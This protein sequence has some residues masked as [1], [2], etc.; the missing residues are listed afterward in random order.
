MFEDRLTDLSEAAVRSRWDLLPPLGKAIVKHPIIGSGFGTTVTYKS[1]DPRAVQLSPDGQFTTYAFE[2]GYLDILLKIGLAGLVVYLLLIVKIWRSGW[3][4]GR[5]GDF[6][7]LGLLL[8]ISALL[9][10][11]FFS[12]YLNHPLGIGYILLCNS[13]FVKLKD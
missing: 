3:R 8:G 11:N 2:W 10:T 4:S 13:F 9:A 12:P 6:M 5:S 1:S 7:P